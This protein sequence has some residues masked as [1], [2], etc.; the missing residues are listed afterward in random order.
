MNYTVNK[1]DAK[2]MAVRTYIVDESRINI[3]SLIVTESRVFLAASQS[4]I[5][6]LNYLQA[7]VLKEE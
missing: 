1:R 2:L 3:A 4:K 5:N 6:Q 7:S